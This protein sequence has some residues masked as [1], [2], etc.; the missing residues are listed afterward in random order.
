MVRRATLWCM[1]SDLEPLVRAAFA[2]VSAACDVA[3]RVQ[4]DLS[5]VSRMTKDDKSP[6]TVA[7]FAVQAIVSMGLAKS[8]GPSLIVGEEHAAELRGDGQT[9]LRDAMVDAVRTILPAVTVNEVL[10]A[11]DNC[12]HDA[13]AEAYWTLDPIDGTKGFLRGQQYAIALARIERGQVVL[14]VMGC[15]NLPA[16]RNA[17]LDQAD[18]LG[19][20]YTATLGGGAWEQ[21]G[22]SVDGTCRRIS[23]ASFDDGQ[24]IRA[25]ESVEA[26]HSKHDDAARVLKELGGAGPAARLD[27]QCKYAVVARGQADVYLRMPTKKGYIEKI[28]DHA[29]GALIAVEAGAVVTDIA[30]ARLDFTHGRLLESNR[31]IVCAAPAIHGRVIDAIERLG[32]GV[33]V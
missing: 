33:V 5:R 7:D 29:A 14:G 21:V 3:R 20:I 31:G 17:T 32:I 25:C 6:V 8:L 13:T 15:P 11:I 2:S 30:G 10:D 19:T 18:T 26:A 1:K 23:T 16:D 24:P 27:S 22:T 28:W 12:D 9:A 4:R